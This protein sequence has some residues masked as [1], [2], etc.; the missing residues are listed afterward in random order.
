[1]IPGQEGQ[2]LTTAML[3]AA[4][5]EQQKQMLGERI[6]PKVHDLQVGTAAEYRAFSHC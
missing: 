2:Q 5:E 1:M 3:A 4:T 6:F